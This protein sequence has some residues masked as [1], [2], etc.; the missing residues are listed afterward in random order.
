M[1]YHKTGQLYAFSWHTRIWLPRG[2]FLS[3]ARHTALCAHSH[4]MLQCYTICLIF[5]YPTQQKLF[6]RFLPRY[7]N[8][9]SKLKL[10]Y[11]VLFGYPGY[12]A[13]LLPSAV[14][15]SRFNFLLLPCCYV[16]ATLII[17]SKT[18]VWKP[19]ARGHAKLGLCLGW[20]TCHFSCLA[21]VTFFC[22]VTSS[23]FLKCCRCYYL[24]LFASLL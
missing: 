7:R 11:I 17:F 24:S 16:D 20:P 3:L 4:T 5:Q 10:L 1:T 6:T 23:G 21:A 9:I 13:E 19:R 18:R 15:A 12:F 2:L 8:P 22:K 14:Y